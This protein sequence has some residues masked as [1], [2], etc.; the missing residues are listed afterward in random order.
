MALNYIP[1]MQMTART[2]VRARSPPGRGFFFVWEKCKCFK[3]IRHG[4]LV[5]CVYMK[6]PTCILAHL[7]LRVLTLIDGRLFSQCRGEPVMFNSADLWGQPLT[8]WERWLARCWPGANVLTQGS[9]KPSETTR[10]EW[11]MAKIRNRLPPAMLKDDSVFLSFQRCLC[12]LTR[13]PCFAACMFVID[14]SLAKI[15]SESM[16]LHMPGTPH[17]TC[18]H[19]PA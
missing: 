8:L 7:L 11:G 6:S 16:R 18:V 19:T 13:A 15:T 1:N 2:C 14:V 12:R 17:C 9:L 5:T 4:S 3:L 10:G